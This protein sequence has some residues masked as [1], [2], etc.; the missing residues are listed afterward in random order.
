MKNYP[1]MIQGV[2]V[3]EATWVNKLALRHIYL[4]SDPSSIYSY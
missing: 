1:K 4:K 3:C 2:I